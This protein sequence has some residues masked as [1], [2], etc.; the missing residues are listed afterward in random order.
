MFIF[1]W[2]Y[3]KWEAI[4]N[5]LSLSLSLSVSLSLCT[6]QHLSQPINDT[7]ASP[8]G[9]TSFQIIFLQ[10]KVKVSQHLGLLR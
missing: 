1:R 7:I 6:S 4:V 8:D 10:E 2:H 9:K 3:E 5:S